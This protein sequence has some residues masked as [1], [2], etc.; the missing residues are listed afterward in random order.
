MDWWLVICKKRSWVC[1]IIS[2]LGLPL[3]HSEHNVL[4]HAFSAKM[5]WL[6]TYLFIICRKKQWWGTDR[7]IGTFAFHCSNIFRESGASFWISPLSQT[8]LVIPASGF[9]RG[10]TTGTGGLG[11]LC[12]PRVRGTLGTLGTLVLG[13][14]T[15]G[16]REGEALGLAGLAVMDGL[17]LLRGLVM[18]FTVRIPGSVPRE[19][20]P[21]REVSPPREVIE[22]TERTCPQ[23]AALLGTCWIWYLCMYYNIHKTFFFID[24]YSA[25]RMSMHVAFLIAHFSG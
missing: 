19:V 17:G 8:A 22:R 13:T 1:G 2:P 9:F 24:L 12:F 15:D 5:E 3:P 20:V 10:G 11:T 7:F 23:T 6:L 21:P 16:L 25:S 14:L 18:A 4:G